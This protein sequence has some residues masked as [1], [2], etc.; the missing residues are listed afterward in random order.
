MATD[1][2]P[3]LSP[4]AAYVHVPFCAHHCGY[5]DFAVSTGVDERIDEYVTAVDR[6][7]EL[8]LGEPAPVET[9]FIGGGTPTYLSAGQI[10]RLLSIVNRWFPARET[11]AREFSIESTPESLDDDKVAVLADHGVNRVSIGVQSFE[12][13]A[14]AVL[15]R[16]HSPADVPRAVNCIRRR[17]DNVSLDLIFG[18][19]GQTLTDWEADVK[20]AVALAPEHISTY[21]L[22]YEKGT[23][24]WKQRRHGLVTALDEEAELAMYQH[25]LDALAAAGYRHYEVSN[26]ARPG[27]ECRHNG[28]YW[29]NWAYFG[30]GVGAARYVAGTRNVNT[31]S[32]P[33]YLETIAAGRPATAQSETLQPEDRARETVSTQL[34]RAEG[35]DRVQF[36]E[37]TGFAL[38][39]LCG[40]TMRRHVAA[41][42]LEV[43]G[44]NVAL[45]R[46][47]VCVADTIIVELMAASPLSE[48][49]KSV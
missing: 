10:D 24:L 7:L 21:G 18:V 4:R 30:A 33:T 32:L 37:Q 19:P 25:A 29:A 9:I 28:V 15:E 16:I 42:L 44:R 48:T 5:C 13:S 49:A 1:A 23:R 12:R 26:H 45:S 39:D 31:R 17:I 11:Q 47:G 41:G 6:E 20:R 27:R 22:T 14:L 3:W 40:A 43:D 38:D 8:L 2:P 35:I 46:S 34:R 36:L